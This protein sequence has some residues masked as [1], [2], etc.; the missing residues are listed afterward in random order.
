MSVEIAV[1]SDAQRKGVPI[2]VGVAEGYEHIVFRIA[3]QNI[4]L[5]LEDTRVLQRLLSD[6]LQKCDEHHKGYVVQ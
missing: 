2:E 4:G 6:A 5:T 3:D 1:P